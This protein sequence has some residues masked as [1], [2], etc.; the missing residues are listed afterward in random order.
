MF[1]RTLKI[2]P[3]IVFLTV[4]AISA[5]SAVIKSVKYEGCERFS[6][7]EI[8]EWSELKPGEMFSDVNIFEA[9]NRILDNFAAQGHYFAS[10]DS[11][12]EEYSADLSE[13]ILTIF[14]TE[15]P[16]IQ[17]I[18]VSIADSSGESLPEMESFFYSRKL[19]HPSQLEAG[20]DET[21][22]AVEENGYPFSMLKLKGMQLLRLPERNQISA[23]FILERGP[24]IRLKGVEIRGNEST[25]S[26]FIVR[27]T[28]I[29]QK[30]LFSAEAFSRAQRYLQRT[31]LFDEVKPLDIIRRDDDFFALVKVKEGRHNS[32]DGAVGYIPG[33]EN[34]KGYWTGLV[35]FAFNN[36][37]GT[38]RKFK[39][40]WEQPDRYSQDIALSYR[41]PW[42][43]GIPLDLS[44]ALDQSVRGSSGF[45]SLGGNDRFLTR[46][47][48]L[49]AYFSLNENI[50]IDGGV[51]YSE[52]L[53]DSAARYIVEIPHSL[54]WGFQGGFT[55]D[56]RDNHLNP[57]SGLFYRNLVQASDKKNYVAPNSSIPQ[58]VDEKRL[59]ID[60]EAVYPLTEWG[61]FDLRFCGRH[62]Q[63]GQEAIPISEMY[64]L[65]GGNSLRGYREEQF[66]GN[67]IAWINLEYRWIIGKY[68]RLF[69]FND[70]GYY[71]RKSAGTA[72]E[73][74]SVDNWNYGYGA[75]IRLET[76]VGII[77]IDYGLGKGDSPMNGKL[78]LRLRNEF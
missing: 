42:V 39:I 2:F 48:S 41:E 19:F 29:K 3:L 38:G 60:F 35:D 15:G 45:T 57:I 47:M 77:G 71:Y 53:P 11:I 46:N 52:V 76:G 8:A 14:L 70:W 5:D 37:F 50:E 44:A 6:R 66:P 1:P 61:V 21:L 18:S 13:V 64:L 4:L 25:R 62:L 63:S 9:F 65:G 12:W 59:E 7:R 67:S 73:Y 78:H 20:I 72:G 23:A 10:I 27:E 30:A 74:I 26:R 49:N 36:L 17:L 56:T 40:H 28:R 69:V 75:G 33:T 68:S 24:Q 16:R 32:I 55:I 22:K 34:E 58:S 54:A 31:R 43:G 51:T